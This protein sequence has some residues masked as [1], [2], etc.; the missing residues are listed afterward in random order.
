[1]KKEYEYI[2]FKIEGYKYN[3]NKSPKKKMNVIYSF[4]NVATTKL[5]VN[6]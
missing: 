4:N 3:Q 1:M 5:Y 2:C 6:N